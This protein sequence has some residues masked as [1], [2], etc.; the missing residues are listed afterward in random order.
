MFV[1]RRVYYGIVM[2]YVET[3]VKQCYMLRL[4]FV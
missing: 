4:L 3:G 2:N 1:G